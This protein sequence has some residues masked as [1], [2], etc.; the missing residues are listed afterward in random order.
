[1]SPQERFDLVILGSG[2]TAFAAALHA[3]ELG[4]TVV[5]TEERT[6]GGPCANRGCLPS[7]NLIEAAR[8]V[9]EAAHSRYPG[10]SPVQMPI[11]WADLVAQKDEII[12]E[13]R[14]HKYESLLDHPERIQVV[15]GQATFVSDHEVEVQS[16]DGTRRL[17][18]DQILIATGSAPALPS[19]AGLAN[20]PYLTSDLLSSSDD[21]WGT[22]LREQPRSLLILGGG[23]IA[24]ELGQ[25]FARFGTQVT[26]VTRGKSIL[27]GYEPE[28]AEALPETLQ[29]EGPRRATGAHSRGAGQSRH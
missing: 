15:P 20:V 26:L 25:M 17:V 1:M 3:A 29:G 5:M 8:L 23:Y 9:Y 10:L 14:A 27:S 16:L 24:L 28:I 19:L 18:G 11:K 2:S 13:Y 21:P 22:E 6:V 7:K 12:Q 4:K